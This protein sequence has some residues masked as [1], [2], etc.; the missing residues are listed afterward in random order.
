MALVII[1]LLAAIRISGIGRSPDRLMIVMGLIVGFICMVLEATPAGPWLTGVTGSRSLPFAIQSGMAVNAVGWIL[2]WALYAWRQQGQTAWWAK[3]HNPVLAVAVIAT[4][5]AGLA[6]GYDLDYHG[7][8]A[9]VG[10]GRASGPQLAFLALYEGTLITGFTTLTIL[11]ARLYR[12]C[13]SKWLRTS[14]ALMAVTSIGVT[15]RS[16]YTMT[17]LL[18][19]V[20]GVPEPRL[21]WSG[22]LSVYINFPSYLVGFIGIS[23][24]MLEQAQRWAQPRWAL[25]V[26]TPLWEDIRDAFP[27]LVRASSN[28]AEVELRLRDVVV[29]EGL[30]WL[31]EFSTPQALGQARAWTEENRTPPSCQE[32][33]AIARWAITALPGVDPD[34]RH[35]QAEWTL[36]PRVREPDWLLD[37]AREYTRL[38]RRPRLLRDVPCWQ[39]ASTA[40]ATATR[41]SPPGG[42]CVRRV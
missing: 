21:P 10:Q 17:Y 25:R 6:L 38:R 37:V 42:P 8:Y 7:T 4:V 34:P 26:L 39:E 19:Q 15:A 40:T 32:A 41:S 18:P 23:L 9:A 29:H 28:I 5:L 2:A 11:F 13:V 31:R 24:P 1:G 20:I 33:E 3:P 16:W 35:Q 27:W 36:S 12:V 22:E 30:H 14:L